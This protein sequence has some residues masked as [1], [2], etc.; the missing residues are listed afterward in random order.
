MIAKVWG[1]RKDEKIKDGERNCKMT[2][3]RGGVSGVNR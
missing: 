2:R 3:E 1:N